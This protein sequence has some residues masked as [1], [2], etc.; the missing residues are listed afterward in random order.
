MWT[1]KATQGFIQLH[2][3]ICR[4]IMLQ[5]RIKSLPEHMGLS[6]QVPFKLLNKVPFALSFLSVSWHLCS[7][8]GPWN[9]PIMFPSTPPFTPCLLFTCSTLSECLFLCPLHSDWQCE[10][11]SAEICIFRQELHCGGWL[12][13]SGCLSMCL[14]YQCLEWQ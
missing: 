3:P 6:T 4:A 8:F 10:F 2:L 1:T 9:S 13:V 14:Q 7:S 12:L 5:L 11:L